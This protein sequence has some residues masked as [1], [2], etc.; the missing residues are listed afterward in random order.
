[1]NSYKLW[2]EMWEDADRSEGDYSPIMV[3]CS[4]TNLSEEETH[5]KNFLI[6]FLAQYNRPK[7]L[8]LIKEHKLLKEIGIDGYMSILFK[9]GKIGI[10]DAKPL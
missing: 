4:I 8:Q 5:I 9:K 10:S 2:Q 7:L 3:G 1:M 6:M